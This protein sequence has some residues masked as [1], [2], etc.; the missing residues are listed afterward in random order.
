MM[1]ENQVKYYRFFRFR[2]DDAFKRQIVETVQKS[3]RIRNNQ[4]HC[5]ESS[6]VKTMLSFFPISWIL[7]SEEKLFHCLILDNFL[8]VVANKQLLCVCSN[9]KQVDFSNHNLSNLTF[10][11]EMYFYH[12]PPIFPTS[13]KSPGES[14]DFNGIFLA[15]KHFKNVKVST[16]A[17]LFP[18]SLSVPPHFFPILSFFLLAASR[19]AAQSEWMRS[20]FFSEVKLSNLNRKMHTRNV[21]MTIIH[22]R[23]STTKCHNI[24][25]GNESWI[26]K[27]AQPLWHVVREEKIRHE[28]DLIRIRQTN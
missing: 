12:R 19:E 23:H 26:W 13:I 3:H 11:F 17:T 15:I 16:A 25:L 20:P 7:L 6:V 8:I 28:H 22:L 14:D 4:S 9:W 24:F 5:R 10:D 1:L 21:L 2:D 18:L 27:C